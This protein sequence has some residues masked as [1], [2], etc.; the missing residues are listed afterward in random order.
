MSRSS[1]LWLLAWSQVPWLEM[2]GEVRLCIEIRLSA[3]TAS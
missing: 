3:I 2:T 1:N